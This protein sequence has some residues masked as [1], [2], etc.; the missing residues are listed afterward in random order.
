MS[1]AISVPSTPRDPVLID[2][3]ASDAW[4]GRLSAEEGR[5]CG[6]L[7]EQG[8]ILL[9][10]DSTFLVSAHDQALLTGI[11]PAFVSAKNV[12]Y[13]PKSGDLHGLRRCADINLV[14]EALARY[15]TAISRLLGVLIPQYT[16][17]WKVTLSSFRPIEEAGR[18]LSGRYRNDR[19]HIDSFP[20]RPTNGDRILRCFTNLN[21]S[22]PRVWL[23]SHALDDLCYRKL[24]T[25]FRHLWADTKS[26]LLRKL[27]THLA[28]ACGISAPRSPYDRFMLRLHDRMKSDPSFLAVPGYRHE[29]SPRSTWLVFTDA[30]PH[31]VLE[32]RFALEQTMIIA[33]KTL[34]LP[35]MAPVAFVERVLGGRVTNAVSF[36]N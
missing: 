14:R 28:E 25:G 7:L 36:R 15:S 29:F 5:A 31:A 20:S 17:S 23:T 4:T 3:I 24:G 16:S 10:R 33:R 35:E 8:R 34:L 19:L 12:S 1:H 32:G 6:E 22:Q 2:R 21:P 11:L 13:D 26:G 30:V 27:R 18:R 9:I